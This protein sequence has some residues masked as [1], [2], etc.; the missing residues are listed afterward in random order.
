[1]SK[2]VAIIR[3]WLCTVPCSR[4]TGNNFPK[5]KALFECMSDG[6]T[7]IVISKGFS[8]MWHTVFFFFHRCSLMAA[9][10][11]QKK[12]LTERNGVLKVIETRQLAPDEWATLTYRLVRSSLLSTK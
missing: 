10:T 2:F 8:L 1:M 3:L 4:H 5:K 12:K 6:E 11:N 7:L 9:N